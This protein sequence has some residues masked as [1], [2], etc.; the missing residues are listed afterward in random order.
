M[1]GRSRYISVEVD[2]NDELDDDD[3][4]EMVKERGLSSADEQTG[5]STAPS[6]RSE[7]EAMLADIRAAAIQG[8]TAHMDVLLAPLDSLCGPPIADLSARYMSR[9]NRRDGARRASH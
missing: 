5:A 7:W 8:D 2:I 1:S 6:T 3:L 9:E 4:L